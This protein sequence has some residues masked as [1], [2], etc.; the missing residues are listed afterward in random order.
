MIIRVKLCTHYETNAKIGTQQLD[1]LGNC[2]RRLNFLDI[3]HRMHIEARA[4]AP[5]FDIT[6][7]GIWTLLHT[8]SRGS[9]TSKHKQG[10]FWVSYHITY[11]LS[12]GSSKHKRGI[13]GIVPYHILIA[14]STFGNDYLLGNIH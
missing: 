10:I 3:V 2:Q 4:Q 13:F 14:L 9:S 6:Q 1:F 11:I 7:M 5:R 8:L 12:R